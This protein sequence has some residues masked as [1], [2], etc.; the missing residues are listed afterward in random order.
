MARAVKPLTDTQLKTAKVKD[1]DYVLSDGNG[2]QFKFRANGSRLWNF[3][4][5]HPHTK[6]RINMGLG[7]YPTVSL[8]Q[9]RKLTNEAR[10]LLAQHIDP[11]EERDKQ[12]QLQQASTNN[13]LMNV[14][15]M[16]FEVKKSTVTASYADDIWRSFE[17]H[18]FPLLSSTPISQIS[19]PKVINVLK[20]LEA[21]GSL[22]TVK[23]VIQR[24]N[25]V[26]TFAVNTG[27]IA[28]NPLSGI[29]ASFKKPKKENLLALTPQELPELLE[30]VSEASIKKVTRYLLL[31]QLHTMTRP[32]EAAK[33]EW[34][35]IDWDN[36][37]WVIPSDKMKKRKEHIIP[38]TKQT[39][40]LL[41]KI[42][43]I[44]G[45]GPYIFPSDRNPK[46]HCN[47]QTVNM[48]I[49]RM[50]FAGRL[51]SH[52]FRSIAS[53]TLN[54]QGFDRDVIEA[55]LAHVDKNEVRRA[56][57]RSDYLDKRRGLMA[58]WSEHICNVSCV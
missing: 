14:A 42:K 5:Y 34:Q 25:E 30:A 18:A 32:N 2:L 4:Y 51:V 45:H 8:K 48:A 10:E 37:L 33:A 24:L 31:W 38:L 40:N 23:R 17:L 21:K 55:T 41:E 12:F 47:T 15:S 36:N 49:K 43:P 58:W 53:T 20:P 56:Y 50:G 39:L 27:I 6:K 16:W 28:S 11:K 3:N 57:N 35:E 29:K 9:A 52:G 54:E 46:T 19:A 7:T 1:K 22:E 44:S 26:M 13:T